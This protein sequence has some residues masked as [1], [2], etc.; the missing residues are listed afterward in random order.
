MRRF[1]LFILGIDI[2]KGVSTLVDHDDTQMGFSMH[3]I[4]RRRCFFFF[5]D[6]DAYNFCILFSS[7]QD[8][9]SHQ[10]QHHFDR[11]NITAFT[12]IGAILASSTSSISDECIEDTN[13]LLFLT[14]RS[15]SSLSTIRSMPGQQSKCFSNA[16]IQGNAKLFSNTSP[17]HTH[18]HPSR[19]QT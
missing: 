7:R 11:L 14:R 17:P 18:S 16:T 2:R 12:T 1:V 9:H 6:C 8:T 3:L 15:W 19:I 13:A 4:L 5:S 10:N